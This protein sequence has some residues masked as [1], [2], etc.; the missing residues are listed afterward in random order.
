MVLKPGQTT[1][2]SVTT[3]AAGLHALT[4][5]PSLMLD[6]GIQMANGG[7]QLRP[8]VPFLVEVTNLGSKRKVIPKNMVIS[9]VGGVSPFDVVY[10]CA[11]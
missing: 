10:R 4:P 2:V 3:A 1:I 5:K 6:K 7:V 9:S 11:K 8:N